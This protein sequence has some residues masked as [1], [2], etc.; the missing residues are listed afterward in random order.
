MDITN[1]QKKAIDK[2]NPTYGTG[3]K[4]QLKISG[5]TGVYSWGLNSSEIAA[6]QS[7]R[8]KIGNS[9]LNKIK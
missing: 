2:L 7:L 5:R 8:N 3:W 4:E 1:E 9:G 6:L